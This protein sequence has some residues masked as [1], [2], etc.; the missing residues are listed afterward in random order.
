MTTVS[1]L[2]WNS[3]PELDDWAIYYFGA[4]G[5]GAAARWAPAATS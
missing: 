1:L 5:L 2:V 3:R 4:Y